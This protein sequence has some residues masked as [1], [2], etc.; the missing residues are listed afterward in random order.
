[1]PYGALFY[2]VII[3]RFQFPGS[4]VHVRLMQEVETV[5][6]QYDIYDIGIEHAD[7][8]I[9]SIAAGGSAYSLKKAVRNLNRRSDEQ[10][11]A[12]VAKVTETA[13]HSM[14]PNGGFSLCLLSI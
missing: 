8:G 11:A 3:M 12:D 9:D 14:P 13:W 10:H 1:M 4:Q 5:D 2:E 7:G 6:P